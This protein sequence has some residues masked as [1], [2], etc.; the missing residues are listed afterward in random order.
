MGSADH[1]G[2]ALPSEKQLDLLRS[3]LA[4]WCEVG[5]VAVL[6]REST[7]VEENSQCIVLVDGVAGGRRDR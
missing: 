7:L 5:H 3:M 2:S 1:G 4:R 6:Q